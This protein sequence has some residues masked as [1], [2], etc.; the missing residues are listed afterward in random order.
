MRKKRLAEIFIDAY[1]FII[2]FVICVSIFI[3]LP[4]DSSSKSDYHYKRYSNKSY[5]SKSYNSTV[6]N[7]KSYDNDGSYSGYTKPKNSSSSKNYENSYD[8]GYYDVYDNQDYDWD[9][10]QNDYD[11]ANGVED[12]WLDWE[13]EE[14][15]W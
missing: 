4:E 14:G 12:A 15:E 3:K 5:S 8:E 10:Y 6:N 1:V 9:R 2:L 13:E 11:Y 7:S